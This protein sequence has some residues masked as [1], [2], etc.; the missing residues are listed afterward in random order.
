MKEYWFG[1]YDAHA[2]CKDVDPSFVTTNYY[3]HNS[4]MNSLVAA[5]LKAL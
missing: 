5:N 3:A 4:L 2:N 1:C